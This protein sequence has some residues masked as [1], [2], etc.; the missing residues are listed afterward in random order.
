MIGAVLLLLAISLISYAFYKW[1]TLHNDYFKRQNLKYL[2]PS[3]YVGNTGGT[4][5]NKYTPA[6]FSD[7]IFQAFPDEP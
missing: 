6:E 7:M 4:F 3:F 2:K 1:A 5:V